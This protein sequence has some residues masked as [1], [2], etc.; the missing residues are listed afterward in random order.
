M[1][2]T[3]TVSDI[4]RRGNRLYVRFIDGTE[5]EGT[6]RELR[7]HCRKIIDDSELT[8][9]LR[10][11]AIAKGL[12]ITADADNADD[13]DTLIGKQFVFNQRAANNICRMI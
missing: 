3:V 7:E 4:Q 2:A 1:P 6:R 10:A 5:I 9:L 8:E 12:R 13:L 11:I